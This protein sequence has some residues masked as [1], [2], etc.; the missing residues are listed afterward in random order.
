MGL[1]KYFRGEI[2][3]TKRFQDE[4]DMLLL[5][6]T[7]HSKQCKKDHHAYGATVFYNSDKYCDYHN[8]SLSIGR[9]VRTITAKQGYMQKA[10]DILTM[11]ENMNMKQIIKLVNTVMD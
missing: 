10:K 2:A 8:A 5:A 4:L 6:D 11:C 3:M 7:L 9:N 1:R